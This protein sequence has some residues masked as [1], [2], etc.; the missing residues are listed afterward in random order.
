MRLSLETRLQCPLEQAIAEV[1]T[2]RLL[3][4][5][6][7]PMVT[8]Q[9]IEPASFPEIW[10]EGTFWV[11]LLLFGVLPFG[12]QAIVI[13]YPAGEDTFTL[14]DNGYSALIKTWDHKITLEKMG[15]GIRYRDELRIS[16]G[17]LTPVIW[18]FACV[19]FKH[20]QRRCNALAKAGF[21]YS[22]P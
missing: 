16:A 22:A 14:R 19:F 1:K 8:F 7:H 9:P 6:A 13:S 3:E 10:F 20:R 21:N 5:V 12:R 17:I 18:L 11:K 15:G 2:P 4:Y